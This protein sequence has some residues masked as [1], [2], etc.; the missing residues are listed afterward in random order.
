MRRRLHSPSIKR[1]DDGDVS[2]DDLRVE[3]DVI[4]YGAT[5]VGALA[6]PYVSPYLYETKKQSLNTVYGI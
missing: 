2:A 6:S 1:D 4:D 3:P 5:R